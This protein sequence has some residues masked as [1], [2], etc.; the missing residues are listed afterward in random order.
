MRASLDSR[1]I[2]LDRDIPPSSHDFIIPTVFQT[3]PEPQTASSDGQP[4]FL[5]NYVNERAAHISG[6]S[7]DH[8][9]GGRRNQELV[10]KMLATISAST[11]KAWTPRWQPRVAA[12]TEALEQV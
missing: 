2:R 6:A 4:R 3:V 5:G 12:V 8:R 10:G 7:I 9:E 1:K 11:P